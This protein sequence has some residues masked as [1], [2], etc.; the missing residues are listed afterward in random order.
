MEGKKTINNGEKAAD[1]FC[2]IEGLSP[3]TDPFTWL[4]I[5]P[6]WSVNGACC[7]ECV[8]KYM[9]DFI[10]TV[11]ND[12]TSGALL[13]KILRPKFIRGL[14]EIFMIIVGGVY[15]SIRFNYCETPFKLFLSMGKSMMDILNI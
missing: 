3:N 7:K 15:R 13:K 14:T 8:F 6:P 9:K 2:R 11:R 5:R 1:I 4:F 12:N 10:K